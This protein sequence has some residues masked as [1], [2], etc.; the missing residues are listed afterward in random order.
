[1][2]WVYFLVPK[3]YKLEIYL[4][5]FAKENHNAQNIAEISTHIDIIYI[6]LIFDFAELLPLIYLWKPEGLL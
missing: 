6:K 1:M 5:G 4:H 3:I 2:F